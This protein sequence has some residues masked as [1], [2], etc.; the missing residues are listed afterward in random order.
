[1]TRFI[2]GLIVGSAFTASM[3]LA[4]QFYNSSGKPSAPR[5]SIE[6][7]DYFRQ[8]QQQLDIRYVREQA[9]RDRLNRLVQPCAK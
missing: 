9:D 1:M 3:G 2:A 8:R 4:G 7:F 6:S 5:G